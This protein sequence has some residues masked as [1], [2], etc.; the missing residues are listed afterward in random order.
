MF[1]RVSGLYIVTARSTIIASPL[2]LSHFQK[3]NTCLNVVS[4][5]VSD[6]KLFTIT[7]SVHSF[8]RGVNR[9]ADRR[10]WPKKAHGLWISAINRA[11]SRIWKI[12]WIA[13]QLKVL[14][15]FPDFVSLE[16][17]IV[18]RIINFL[19]ALV[20]VLVFC[21]LTFHFPGFR[22]R[23]ARDPTHIHVF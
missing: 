3:H 4:D 14:A 15:R 8:T 9:S 18:D 12:P 2:W 23:L 6:E 11:D 7:Y 20:N 10:I 5:T 16:V 13:G 1:V 21:R 19:S 17:R 22:K